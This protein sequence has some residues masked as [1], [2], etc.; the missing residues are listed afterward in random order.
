[1]AELI[2]KQVAAM[3]AGTTGVG[4]AIN[5]FSF[6]KTRKIKI[7]APTTQV[8][9]Q[10][11]TMGSGVA[12]PI[13]TRFGLGSIVSHAA[14][15]TSVTLDIGIRNFKTKVA[16]AAAGIG[17]ALAVAASGRTAANNGTLLIDG[18]D[19]VTTE[20]SEVYFTYTGAN[21]TDN[22][23]MCVEVEVHLPD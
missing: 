21:P 5:G 16:I 14:Q 9:A 18:A 20:V 3:A 10:N 17:S 15:G 23:Q 1:M 13:G 7:H 8:N 2:S 12:L 19:S 4:K 6:P 11:D 22:A